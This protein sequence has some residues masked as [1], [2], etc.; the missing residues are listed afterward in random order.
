MNYTLIKYFDQDLN[1]E[2]MK[3]IGGCFVY[4]QLI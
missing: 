1:T 3:Y 2:L 4:L